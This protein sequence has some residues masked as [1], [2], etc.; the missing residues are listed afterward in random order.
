MLMLTLLLLA[1]GPE[2]APESVAVLDLRPAAPAD[3][4]AAK[5]LTD[6]LVMAL[7]RDHKGTVVSAREIAARLDA[8]AQARLMGC[9]EEMCTADASKALATDLV[10]AG[11]A[12]MLGDQL[13]VFVS[14]IEARTGT[15][16]ARASRSFSL[17]DDAKKAMRDVAGGL[18]VT[19]V[20][21]TAAREAARALLLP[22]AAEQGDTPFKDLRVA[23][24]LDEYEP[25]GVPAKMR[26]V[27]AC[28]Q[29][30]LLDADANVVS[31]AVVARLK[32]KAGPRKILEGGVPE[33]MGSDE[34]DALVVGVVERT[35]RVFNG[36]PTMTEMA[37]TVQ[38]VRVDSGDVV[39][40]EQAAGGVP[41]SNPSMQVTKSA[42]RLCEKLK[43]L[44]ATALEKRAARGT[45]V[46]VELTGATSDG[47]AAL[48]KRL[49]KLER[50]GRAR[51]R[52][53]DAKKVIVDVVLKAGDGV[54]LV[55]DAGSAFVVQEAS[56]GI[57]KATL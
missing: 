24:M 47:A 31:P 27:E 2:P 25:D 35:Q 7:G 55:L 38:L 14:L 13:H 4:P 32:G 5:L 37:A 21:D 44:L 56:A 40:S 3:G 15:V 10:V 19:A 46:V 50:V 39:A 20:V 30:Q 52:K 16:R 51:V 18:K 23:V 34:V 53:I 8:Q 29:K 48:V 41:H 6:A 22:E 9:E 11:R 26:P 28:I 42:E 12:G 45:R 54:A 36:A 1:A 57:V 49:E 43:P 17:K 33:D